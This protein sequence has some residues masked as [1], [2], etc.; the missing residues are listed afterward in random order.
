[1]R[2]YTPPVILKFIIFALT[3]SLIFHIPLF[4][5]HSIVV[6]A[7]YFSEGKI[8]PHFFVTQNFRIAVSF[9]QRLR[10][11]VSAP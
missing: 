3:P 2:T 1:M 10:F 9:Y 5:G 11:V 7:K 6:V 4:I 8:C